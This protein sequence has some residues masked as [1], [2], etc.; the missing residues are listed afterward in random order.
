ML[1]LLYL[2]I[3]RKVKIK[4]TSFE[5]RMDKTVYGLNLEKIVVVYNLIHPLISQLRFIV[6]SVK[7]NSFEEFQDALLHLHTC[8]I[9]E[10]NCKDALNWYVFALDVGVQNELNI[11]FSKGVGLS[12]TGRCLDYIHRRKLKGIFC[13]HYPL[14]HR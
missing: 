14:C 2:E 4:G 3:K 10:G 11:A 13:F 12:R 6:E 7:G 1:V 5:K 9:G 8:F